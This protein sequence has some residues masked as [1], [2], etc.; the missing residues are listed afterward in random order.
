MSNQRTFP[1]MTAA[2]AGAYPDGGGWVFALV[3]GR[4]D[5]RLASR[6]DLRTFQARFEAN[7]LVRSKPALFFT[8][9]GN[10]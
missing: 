2:S 4:L 8:K 6:S 10:A 9:V 7:A 5:G 3:R 1:Q